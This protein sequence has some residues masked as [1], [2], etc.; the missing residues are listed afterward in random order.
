[1]ALGGHGPANFEDVR[2]FN[3]ITYLT[4]KKACVAR[5]MLADA[6]LTARGCARPFAAKYGRVRQ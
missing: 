6:E 5:G 2:S 4:F 3:G 1:M